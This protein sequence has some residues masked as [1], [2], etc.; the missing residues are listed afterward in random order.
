MSLGSS[1]P[2]NVKI[3]ER[4]TV[5]GKVSIIWLV[6]MK[7]K[8]QLEDKDLHRKIILTWIFEKIVWI[9]F[10]YLRMGTNRWN[11]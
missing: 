4:C 3:E 5:N 2:E 8:S 10:K 6:N 11:S 7:L 1:N 9:L